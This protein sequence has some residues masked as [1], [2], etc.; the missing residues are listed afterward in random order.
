MS[1]KFP[2]DAPSNTEAWF[3]FKMLN[4]DSSD[5]LR[6]TRALAIAAILN[7]LLYMS[8]LG[9]E[10][11]KP[12]LV[13]ISFVNFIM[14]TFRHRKYL[15]P[16]ENAEE[17][18]SLHRVAPKQGFFSFMRRS[19]QVPGQEL[20]LWEPSVGCK[21]LFIFFS[22]MHVIC[23]LLPGLKFLEKLSLSFGCS[24]MNLV[25]VAKY[26][27]RCRVK[28]KIHHGSYDTLNRFMCREFFKPREEMGAAM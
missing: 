4:L 23:F 16:S 18:T 9:P 22:P 2:A 25:L 12:Y 3:L 28:D 26:E 1:S 13:L 21:V 14:F 17:E 6:F 27:S 20:H 11:L 19:V 5:L 7:Y 24:L 8:C 10:V 15:I